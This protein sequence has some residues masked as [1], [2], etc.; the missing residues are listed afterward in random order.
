MLRQ[1][2]LPDAGAYI[3]GGKAFPL[4]RGELRFYQMPDYVL[5]TADIKGLPESSETGFFGLHIHEGGRCT[6]EAFPETG[7]HYNPAGEP[8]PRHAGDLPP[9]LLCSGG[10]ARMAVC[11]SRFRLDEIIGRTVVIHSGADDFISQPAGN[12]GAKIAC[13]V[14]ERNQHK[15]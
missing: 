3:A 6:G 9:L 10:R 7:S 15:G 4:L 2:K 5:V 8:H 14:I 1:E 12:A 11:T 13:G